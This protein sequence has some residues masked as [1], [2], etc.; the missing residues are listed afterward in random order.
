MAQLAD[1]GLKELEVLKIDFSD[2]DG[3]EGEIQSEK[4][5][6]VYLSNEL[7]EQEGVLALNRQIQIEIL[8]KE[9]A[10][11]LERLEN[12]SRLKSSESQVERLLAEFDARAELEKVEQELG[13]AKQRGKLELPIQGGRVVSSF[14]RGFDPTS[15]LQ[16]FKKGIE[17]SGQASQSVTAIS[18][19]KVAFTGELP[20]YGQVIIIDHGDHFYSLLGHLGKVL[21][22][23][24]DFV[25]PGELIG[26]M[27]LKGSPIYFEIRSG[28]VAVNPLQ[29]VV[30]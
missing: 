14:G 30:N 24:K 20:N 11:S 15:G 13:F 22:K 21:K 26:Q 1:R 9:K 6:V 10:Q 28:N 12:Y 19:G 23:N 2:L 7:Q 4:Q 25:S 5:Q 8:K 3:L 16:I 17:V 18:S 29:W 27:D